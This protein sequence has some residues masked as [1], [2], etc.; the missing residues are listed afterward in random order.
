MTPGRN[1]KKV[2]D[3]EDDVPSGDT[4]KAVGSGQTTVTAVD[5]SGTPAA[6]VKDVTLSG[7]QL[8]ATIYNLTNGNDYLVTYKIQTEE[9]GE[10]FDK[11][12]IVRARTR[13]LVV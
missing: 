3:F 4:I 13:G 11:F 6:I 1:E 8:T 5:Q 10:E 12:L 9:S 7:T 2:F